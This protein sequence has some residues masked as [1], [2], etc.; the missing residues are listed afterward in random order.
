MIFK[1]KCGVLIVVTFLIASCSTTF[2]IFYNAL[3][4]EDLSSNL[5]TV[6][7]ASGTATLVGPIGISN[8][9]DIAFEGFTLYGITFSEFLLIDPDTGAGSIVGSLGWSDMNALAVASD[10]TIYAA[11]FSSGDFISINPITGVGTII[12]NYGSG[13]T[14]SGDLAFDSGGTL[15]ASV[16]R[17]GYTNDWLATIDLGTGEATLIGEIGYVDVFGLSF[18]D[19]TLYGVTTDGQLLEIDTFSGAGTLVGVNWI[20][21]WGLSTSPMEPMEEADS[22]RYPIDYTP[23]NPNDWTQD[24]NDFGSLNAVNIGGK[25]HAAEDWNKGGECED[26]GEAVVAIANG[27]V[28]KI[29]DCKEYS[30]DKC[31]DDWG[32][33]I[34]IRHDAPPGKYFLTGT[35]ELKTRVY[36]MYAHLL[37]SDQP[38]YDPEKDLQVGKGEPIKKGGPVGQVGDGNSQYEDACHLHF[39]ILLD[40]RQYRGNPYTWDNMAKYTDPSEF[41]DNNRDLN[42]EK[43]NIIVHTYELDGKFL[44]DDEAPLP[45]PD[46]FNNWKR[47]GYNYSA[48]GELGYNGQIFYKVANEYGTVK[49]KPN[50]PKNGLYRIWVFIP[51]DYA[52]SEN[53]VYMVYHNDTEII[54]SRPINQ[55]KEKGWVSI[56]EEKYLSKTGNPYVLLDGYT[57]ESDKLIAADAVKFEYLGPDSGDVVVVGGGGGG[58]FVATAAYG[59][60]M[61]DEVGILREFRVE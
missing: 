18:K 57:G 14:S 41:I 5:Y 47:E 61:A 17:S 30:G 22:F 59:S 2:A 7:A 35:G 42:H 58:C 40:K 48:Y 21:Q 29:D 12:G 33:T 19:E 4:M 10:R 44:L 54:S 60:P 55:S 36:S 9:T 20:N 52:T 56:G 34:L 11:G 13:L 46:S 43:F 32:R 6:D 45:T 26:Q 25:P 49:W 51:N 38:D 1:L 31:D 15:Y 16:K 37:S 28:E 27:I 3:Y 24:K 53:A 23:E 50:L 39:E 8:V